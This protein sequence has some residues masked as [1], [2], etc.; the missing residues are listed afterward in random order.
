MQA[1]R[2]DDRR[3]RDMGVRRERVRIS[4]LGRISTH[5][6]LSEGTLQ[7]IL[8]AS[9]FSTSRKTTPDAAVFRVG[10]CLTDR[11]VTLGQIGTDA[12][13]LVSAEVLKVFLTH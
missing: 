6:N 4:T 11:A 3:R 13:C 12:P 2:M 8:N 5:I 9:R 7:S 1:P 10:G